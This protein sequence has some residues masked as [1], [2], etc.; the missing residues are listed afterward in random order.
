MGRK[1]KLKIYVLK[2]KHDINGN[3]VYT[4][5]IPGITGK[6]KGLRKLKTPH[7]YNKQSYNLNQGLKN[8][9]FKNYDVEIIRSWKNGCK[10]KR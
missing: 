7:M 4:L 3:P 9:V 2:K 1:K 6:I 10:T 8:Y 5:F